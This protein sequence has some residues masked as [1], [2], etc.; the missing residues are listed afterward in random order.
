MFKFSK[1]NTVI[2]RVYAVVKQDVETRG[3]NWLLSLGY[4][5][6]NDYAAIVRNT[7]SQCSG[8]EHIRSETVGVYIRKYKRSLKLQQ[9][10]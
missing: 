6:C 9:P 4:Q 2:S 1:S 7:V 10:K 5:E 3:A 8:F